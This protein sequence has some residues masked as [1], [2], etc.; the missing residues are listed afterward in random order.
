MGVQTKSA[1][2]CPQGNIAVIAVLLQL[3]NDGYRVRLWP[4]ASRWPLPEIDDYWIVTSVEDVGFRIK[5]T[6]S[7]DIAALGYEHIR[8]FM[9]DPDRNSDGLKH[10]ILHLN[11]GLFITDRDV[12]IQPLSKR[13]HRHR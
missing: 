6:R 2:L 4:G 13:L 7:Y 5:N 3:K 12:L 10:G 1:Q 9:P 11:V 8:G